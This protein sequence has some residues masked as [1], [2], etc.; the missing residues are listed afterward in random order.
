LPPL[1]S[2]NIATLRLKS[3]ITLFYFAQFAI[4][5]ALFII[6]EIVVGFLL[7][8]HR[9]PFVR[10]LQSEIKQGV[11]LDYGTDSAINKRIDYIQEGV[12]D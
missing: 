12:S 4:C 10:K 11:E 5:A 1:H 9:E 2:N 3:R 8:N 6:G 7:Y